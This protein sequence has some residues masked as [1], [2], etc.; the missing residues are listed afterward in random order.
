ML[1]QT[2]LDEI[3][4]KE[5]DLIDKAVAL[6]AH[7]LDPAEQLFGTTPRPFV[8]AEQAIKRAGL[9]KYE[10]AVDDALAIEAGDAEEHL[11]LQVDDRTTQLSGVSRL[12]S[13]KDRP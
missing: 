8:V 10:I 7:Q 2:Q 12:K 6:L 3:V 11:R 5:R 4:G 13:H 1:T 9:A